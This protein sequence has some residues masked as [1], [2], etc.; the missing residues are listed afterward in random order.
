MDVHFLNLIL[1]INQISIFNYN[2]IKTNDI[3]FHS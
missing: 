1:F 3:N 2:F